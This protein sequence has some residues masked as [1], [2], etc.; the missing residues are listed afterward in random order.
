M[1][2]LPPKTFGRPES[3]HVN[4]EKN[5]DCGTS[6]SMVAWWYILADKVS[7]NCQTVAT[8]NVVWQNLPQSQHSPYL[9]G[10]LDMLPG[11][12]RGKA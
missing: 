12:P 10:T 1:G 2:C 6:W 4:V 11:F 3:C 8:S 7:Q 9:L 5:I